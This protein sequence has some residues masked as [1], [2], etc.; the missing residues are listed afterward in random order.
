MNPL[1]WIWCFIWH[2][3]HWMINTSHVINNRYRFIQDSD[4]CLRCGRYKVRIRLKGED[5]FNANTEGEAS[6]RSE[7]HVPRV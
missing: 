1:K 7:G 6:P 3:S 5:F 2:H 4:T